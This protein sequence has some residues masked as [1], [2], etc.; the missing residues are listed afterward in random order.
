MHVRRPIVCL[1]AVPLGAVIALGAACL[2]TDT[3][4]APG[5]IRLSVISGDP[6]VTETVDGWSIAVDKLLVGV[7]QAGVDFPCNVY[8]N[9]RYDRLLDARRPEEQKIS[10]SFGL[11]QCYFA[12]AVS[13]PSAHA[14]LGEG[15]TRM[16]FEQM[17]W[18]PG[19]GGPPRGAAPGVPIRGAPGVPIAIEARATRGSTTKR[20][21]WMLRPST[22]YTRCGLAGGDEPTAIDLKSDATIEMRMTARGAALF[23][24][25]VDP[26][27]AALRFDPVALADDEVG[28]GDGNVTLD[29]LAGVTLSMARKFGPYRTTTPAPLLT[30]EDYIAVELVPRLMQPPA[31]LECRTNSGRR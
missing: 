3:R 21:H 11:G 6:A 20:I 23:Q 13:S 19:D 5:S 28:D 15:V 24:D 4:P 8:A 7:G 31:G 27:T 25:G 18:K 16:D 22:G 12:F 29:E 17:T 30:L 10:Q 1:A 2:P 9:A 14:L 26:T